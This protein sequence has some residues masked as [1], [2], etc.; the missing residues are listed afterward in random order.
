[1]LALQAVGEHN[2]S[3]LTV[4]PEVVPKSSPEGSKSAWRQSCLAGH[5]QK[6]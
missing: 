6:G 1:M 4:K 5:Q 3:S 2:R